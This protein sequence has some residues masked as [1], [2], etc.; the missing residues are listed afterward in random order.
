MAMVFT[1]YVSMFNA[2]QK[3]E[4]SQLALVANKGNYS[5]RHGNNRLLTITP[6]KTDEV[7]NITIRNLAFIAVNIDAL[8]KIS[9]E[10]KAYHLGKVIASRAGY[11]K[12]ALICSV[13]SLKTVMDLFIAFVVDHDYHGVRV[14]AKAVKPL[15][16]EPAPAPIEKKSDAAPAE[17]R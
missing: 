9:N 3:A 10:D 16:V 7:V 8:N 12:Q 6:N 5:L 15:P 2:V 1:E 14:H 17:E 4:G 11:D 13:D